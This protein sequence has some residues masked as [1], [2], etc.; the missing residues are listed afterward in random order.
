MRK[1]LLVIIMALAVLT[2]YFGLRFD[3]FEYFTQQYEITPAQE[4][5]KDEEL[6]IPSREALLSIS[7]VTKNS[8]YIDLEVEV[9]R[10]ERERAI[11][12]M[13]RESL[14]EDSGMIFVYEED[15][16]EKFW[17]KNCKIHLDMI[18]IDKT[19]V[20]IDIV[21]SA[22]PCYDE[23]CKFYGPS[24]PY[25]FVIETNGG[26]ADGKGINIGDKIKI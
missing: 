8:E 24:V 26:W 2:L 3:L 21:K 13:F 22:P 14:D 18:F 10:T 16:K 9:A 5:E 17:M 4:L 23:P 19:G 1:R 12:L 15:S 6:E 11:G 25:R 7:F 20:I